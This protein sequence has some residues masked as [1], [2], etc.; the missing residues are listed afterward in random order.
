M[1]RI[2]W[3]SLVL[4]V[5][6]LWTAEAPQAAAQPEKGAAACTAPAVPA[7]ALE[8]L[9][10]HYPD[11]RIKQPSDFRPA[12]DP[13]SRLEAYLWFTH[14][15]CPGIASGKLQPGPE[16]TYAFLL[17]PASKTVA[18]FRLVVVT[19]DAKGMVQSQILASTQPAN[20]DWA[21]EDWLI[22][23]VTLDGYA[24]RPR[25][26]VRYEIKEGILM[27]GARS[28]LFAWNNGRYEAGFTDEV[29]RDQ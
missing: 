26:S 9:K 10:Q 12:S 18:G 8:Y 13:S 28:Y 17:I 11:W 2:C 20:K 4:A 5:V 1:R 3:R 23:A 25:S 16:L 7:Y 29:D 27:S 19:R 21:N 6:A 22:R 14:R 24:G 15:R